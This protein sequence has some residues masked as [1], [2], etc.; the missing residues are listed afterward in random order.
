MLS[1]WGSILGGVIAALLGS[2]TTLVVEKVRHRKQKNGIIKALQQEV[3]HNN[4]I[5]Q[6][7]IKERWH[8]NKESASPFERLQTLSYSRARESGI[9]SIFPPTLYDEITCVYDIIFEIHRLRGMRYKIQ[10]SI[11]DQILNNIRAL[12]EG[13]THSY[14]IPGLTQLPQKLCDLEKKLR[15][16]FPF[17]RKKEK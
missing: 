4:L 1:F 16:T 5:M 15:E 17:L 11:K 7:M 13:H 14:E 2:G 8:S 10:G 9:I 3:T 12:D 6:N